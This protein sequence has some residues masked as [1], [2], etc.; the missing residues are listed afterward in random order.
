MRDL[1]HHV[2]PGHTVLVPNGILLEAAR[3]EALGD[4]VRAVAASSLVAVIGGVV[5]DAVFVRIGNS[6]GNIVGIGLRGRCC[7]HL[8][9]SVLRDD[10][11][12]TYTGLL[13]LR[14]VFRLFRHPVEVLIC[15]I[16]RRDLPVALPV[17]LD[18]QGE[19]VSV[20]CSVYRVRLLRRIADR[21]PL[22]DSESCRFPVK[23]AVCDLH[24]GNS[25]PDH[26]RSR[27]DIGSIFPLSVPLRY[28]LSGKSAALTAAGNIAALG[29]LVVL[30][31]FDQIIGLSSDLLLDHREV[32]RHFLRRFDDLLIR[33]G[34]GA[35]I[36]LADRPVKVPGSFRGALRALCRTAHVAHGGFRIR[37]QFCQKP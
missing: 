33:R 34:H 35:V 12:I 28:D 14:G 6:C 29:R 24:F 22:V 16:H 23:A 2:D 3:V 30:Y 21:H 1:L 37:L 5:V 9:G 25:C 8:F 36:Q 4:E 15:I 13:C 10:L 31:V 27:H 26:V 18:I 19:I 11:H 7:H 17:T 32:G 20:C